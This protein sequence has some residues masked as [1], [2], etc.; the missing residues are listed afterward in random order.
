MA[1]TFGGEETPPGIFKGTEATKKLH[2]WSS[3]HVRANASRSN[4]SPGGSL[5]NGSSEDE[6]DAPITYRSAFPIQ[7]VH[8]RGEKCQG[9][10]VGKPAQSV[11]KT[12][13]SLRS[14]LVR[15]SGSVCLLLTSQ[16]IASLA[17]AENPV[18]Q[19]HRRTSVVASTP[20]CSGLELSE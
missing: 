4:S 14:S 20:A 5:V 15:C 8:T 19:S 1:I 11:R 13:S 2:R 9:T 3:W 16:L 10:E 12:V 6:Y 18:S 17:I 7:Q